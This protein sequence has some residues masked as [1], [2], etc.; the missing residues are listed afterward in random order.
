MKNKL[1]ITY[2][3]LINTL[4]FFSCRGPVKEENKN[5]ASTSPLSLHIGN[6]KY[7]IIDT[8]ESVVNWKGAMEIGSNSHS[9]YVD[10]SKGELRVENG[11][12]IGGTVE[13]DMNTIKDE[14]HRDDSGLILHLKDPDFFDVK[15]FP[16]SSITITKAGSSSGEDKKITGNLTIKGITNP[17][18]FP[19][20]IEVNGGIVPLFGCAI[21]F[22]KKLK[23]SKFRSCANNRRQWQSIPLLTPKP[24]FLKKTCRCL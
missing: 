7:F 22:Q 8:K 9:G 3:I 17:I 1:S 15:K 4:L 2:L 13:V 6:K 5:N 23:K 19:A 24:L 11:Q 10:I 21:F 20:K 12:L 18:T 16:S 14:K